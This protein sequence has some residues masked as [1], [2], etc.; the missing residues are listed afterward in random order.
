LQQ[1]RHDP[2]ISF[3]YEPNSIL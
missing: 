3:V 1:T 2:K